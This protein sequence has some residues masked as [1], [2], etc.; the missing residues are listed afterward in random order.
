MVLIYQQVKCLVRSGAD[1]N[2]KQNNPLYRVCERHF[3]Q[4]CFDGR[5][6]DY[7]V[8]T[9]QRPLLSIG[10]SVYMQISRFPHVSLSNLQNF[11]ISRNMNE[12]FGTKTRY[13]IY[14][15]LLHPK[16]TGEISPQDLKSILSDH[17]VILLFIQT[18]GAY[19]HFYILFGIKS[20]TRIPN[21]NLSLTY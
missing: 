10:R 19:T 4:G 13:S 17:R 20:P 16:S 9:A 18:C 11:N 15:R 2:R 14:L 6:C 5:G 21:K 8:I 1:T 7:L 12:K 3:F